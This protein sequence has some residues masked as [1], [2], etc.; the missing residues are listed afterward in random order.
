MTRLYNKIYNLSRW[1]RFGGQDQIDKVFKMCL[2]IRS[3]HV[4][5]LDNTIQYIWRILFSTCFTMVWLVSLLYRFCKVIKSFVKQKFSK[6]R[7]INRL[8]A[9]KLNYSLKLNNFLVLAT[10]NRVLVFDQLYIYLS[11]DLHDFFLHEVVT[12]SPNSPK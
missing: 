2:I 12:L 7:W 11:I 6:N 4:N 10:E 5:I 9:N 1:L 8:S 3:I